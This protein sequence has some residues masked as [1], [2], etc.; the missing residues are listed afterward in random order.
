[1]QGYRRFTGLYLA[2]ALIVVFLANFLNYM[3][4]MLVA[5]FEE[6]VQKQ[7]GVGS[8]RFGLLWTAFTVGYMIT[9][10]FIGYFADRIRR[11]WLFALCIA[12]WS[13]ATI[14]CGLT[15][16]SYWIFVVLRVLVGVG[17]A[18]CLVIGPT[19]LADYFP[20]RARG[21]ILSVF[22]L[23]VPLGGALG[24]MMAGWVGWELAFF[25][26]GLPGLVLAG[27]IALLR[28]PHRGATE[29]ASVEEL[30]RV[31]PPSASLRS[32]VDLLK[33]RTLL[34]IILAQALAAFTLA[35]MLMFSTGFFE[36]HGM[37][38]TEVT[39][40][41][42][43]IVLIGGP[44]GNFLGGWLGDKTRGRDP[45]SYALLAAV[46]Y[47]TALPSL[48]IGL[49]LVPHPLSYV[50]LFL[51]L[52]M[53]FASMPLVNTQ[54]ANV[55]HPSQR[56]VAFALAVFIMHALGDALSTPLFGVVKSLKGDDLF[57]F[58]VFPFALL[59]GAV[60]CILARNSAGRDVAA[61]LARLERDRTK[62]IGR[63][64]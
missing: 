14:G 45:G 33:T 36:G 21:R 16:E 20:R 1:M 17:E 52:T 6:E 40:L 61:A 23:G 63:S 10:P 13:G 34:F 39:T 37:T 18:G 56:A 11:T 55:V 62:V 58:T 41:L 8:G 30:T 64:M 12:V 4:R 28:E 19:L 46:G 48:V 42:G 32:Y 24:Y 7:F 27:L 49:H 57:A 31:V 60:F 22:F 59:I 43:F 35:P 2:F 25:A 53:L 51:G 9:A 50:L 54:L 26:A 29:A 38:K 3:D 47:S 5:A 15:K 44:L